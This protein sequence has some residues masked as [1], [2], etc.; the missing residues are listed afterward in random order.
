MVMYDNFRQSDICMI[1][2]NVGERQYQI[3]AGNK[4]FVYNLT[5]GYFS[6]MTCSRMLNRGTSF[7]LALATVRYK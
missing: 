4:P 1:I 2:G 6:G 7:M 5:V 3:M